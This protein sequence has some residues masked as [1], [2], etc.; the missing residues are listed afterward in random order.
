MVKKE[1]SQDFE[2]WVANYYKSKVDSCR[3][4]GIAF[5]LNLMSVRNLL[6][7]KVCGYTGMQMTVPKI[8]AKANTQTDVTIDRI[9]NTRPYEKGNVIAVSNV[10]NNFKA[11]FENPQY[12]LDMLTAQK[13]LVKM[14]KK[15]KQTKEK[16]NAQA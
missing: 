4:R 8:G 1:F 5:N 3:D 9:D 10:A 11:I 13:A 7:S 16:Q 2:L 6:S 15:I 12:K 14:Q